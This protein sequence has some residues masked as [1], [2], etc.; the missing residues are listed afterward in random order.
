MFKNKKKQAILKLDK[1]LKED[2]VDYEVIQ[3][4]NIINKLNNYYTTSSCAG[5]FLLISKDDVRDKYNTDFIYKTH[6]PD[7]IYQAKEYLN[8]F[9]GHLW[10]LLEA[11]NFHVGCIDLNSAI[12]LHKL[13]LKAGF[14]YSKIQSLEPSI[15][16]EILGTSRI[17]SPLGHKNKLLVNDNYIDYI[18]TIC[19]KLLK[20]EQMKLKVWEK[21]LSETFL[22]DKKI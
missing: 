19:N 12:Q 21:L 3:L 13:S 11:P 4:I 1:A 17:S 14:G 16:V 7:L 20:E 8:N 18:C 22:T 5:R 6:D 2:K 9:K 10:L 15:V